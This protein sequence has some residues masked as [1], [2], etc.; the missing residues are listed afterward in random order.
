VRHFDK[1]IGIIL[2]FII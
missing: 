2:F 1:V